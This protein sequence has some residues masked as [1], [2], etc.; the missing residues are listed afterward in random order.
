[1]V[2]YETATG[3]EVWVSGVE[4]RFHDPMGSGP[5]GT[6]TYVDGKLYCQGATGTLLCL[7]A[8]T[9][10]TLWKRDVGEDTGA[11]IPT[12]GFAGSP[13]VVDDLVFVF[14]GADEGKSVIAYDRSTGDEVWTSG[15]GSHG[16]S[17][18]HMA[19]I[20]G[21]P[22]LLME[23]NRG[24][25][26]FDPETGEVLWDQEWP[27]SPIPRVLQPLVIGERSI[28]LG[29]GTGMGTKLFDARLDSGTWTLE[30]KWTTRRTPGWT[31]PAPL[32]YGR[33]AHPERE[34][35]SRS[36]RSQAG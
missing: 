34:G 2:C 4:A 24:I 5:R 26:S 31:S 30:E 9:G 3:E 15:D 33:S 27:L 36:N 12:W 21:V 18:G 17:S 20:D 23:S 6:P 28:V 13:L 25:Q 19:E 29:S 14:T 35:Q 32:G 10:G 7:D 11:S 1:M 16:Y 8:S 22:Q